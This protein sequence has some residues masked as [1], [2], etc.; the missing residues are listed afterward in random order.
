MYKID[1][2][3]AYPVIILAFVLQIILSGFLGSARVRPDLMIIVTAFFALFSDERFGTEAGFVSG[4]LLDAFTIRLFGLNAM[5]FAFGGYIIG[6]NNNK[7]YKESPIT[8]VIMTFSAS[9][10]I[11]SLYYLVLCLRGS[12]TFIDPV[13]TGLFSYSVLW[14]SLLNAFLAVWVFAFLVRFFGISEAEL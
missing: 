9:F 11:L 3:K 10:I 8:H 5:L 13:F 14:G 12:S 7:F 2:K 1:R 6:K 4:I